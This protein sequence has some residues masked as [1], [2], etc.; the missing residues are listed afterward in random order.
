MNRTSD[1]DGAQANG[2]ARCEVAPRC[3]LE[4]AWEEVSLTLEGV[5]C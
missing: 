5:R 3:S 1:R 2:S 4:D